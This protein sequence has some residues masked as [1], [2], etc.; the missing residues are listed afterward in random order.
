MLHAAFQRVVSILILLVLTLS[1]SL[2]AEES[3]GRIASTTGEV[4]VIDAN[5]ETHQVDVAGYELSEMETVVTAGNSN[6][7]VI[8][9]DG[10][11]SVLGE[12]SRL[13]VEKAG[14][15]S[16]LGGRIYYTFSKLF[17]TS[18][19][20]KTR[21]ATV[22]IRGT[23]FLIYDDAAGQRVALAE[24]L[25]D[26]QSPGPQ[27]ELYRQQLIDQFE[28][29]QQQIVQQQQTLQREFDDYREQI[30]RE[31]IE[32]STSFSLHPN[33]VVRFEG[34]R[35]DES[36][37]DDS[38]IADFADFEAVAG[39]LLDEFREQARLYRE[40]LETGPA[41]EEEDFE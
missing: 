15:L 21:F 31:F 19:Q 1:Q 23:T 16:H 3:R 38:T 26:I 13:R 12:N 30:Y 2:Q 6:A 33:H 17:G 29:Y 18:R 7:V 20:V 14:W 27:F 24:G 34:S 32:Y 9:T 37:M 36:I 39:S 41:L 22:G 35:V 4:Q 11:L 25:L 28:A 8:F 10:A 40:W 5:G